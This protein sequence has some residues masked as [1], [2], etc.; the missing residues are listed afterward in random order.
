MNIYFLVEGQSTE[1]DV[2]P[3][4]LSYLV[5]ELIKV[6]N[7]DEVDHNNY[8]LFSSYGIPYIEEDIVNA[9]EDINSSGKYHYFVICIDA[10]AAT[11]SQR[12]AKIL[13]LISEKQ[14]TLTDNTSL[15]II[16]QNRCIETW[17]LG[18]RKVYTR[19]PQKDSPFIE[20]ARFY[21]VLQDDPELM[22]K[23]GNFNGS[24]SK[25]HLSYLK[26]MFNER[27]NMTYSKSNSTEVQKSSYLN[28]LINRTED[29]PSHLNTFI[30][31][32]EF[33]TEIRR[34]ISM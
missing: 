34:E 19:K 17:F 22:G 9:I 5:P 27:G 15:K 12:E 28:E 18:N 32:V 16:V 33:C 8:Y 23:S 21:N 30:N 4:W 26:A 13:N 11:V 29:E 25:F 1:P 31:F 24:I 10:D 20:Y 7:F 14:I 6:D 2:Y 3:A